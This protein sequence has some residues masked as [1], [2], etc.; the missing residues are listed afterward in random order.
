MENI[1]EII[2]LVFACITTSIAVFKW[3]RCAVHK[4]KAK[5]LGQEVDEETIEHDKVIEL[6]KNL[7]PKAMEYAETN[8]ANGETKKLLAMS[9]LM[10]DC[11]TINIDFSKYQSMIDDTIETFVDFSKKVNTKGE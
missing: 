6:I 11:N 3:V 5:C 2:L 7:I 10:L 1:R 4:A 8:G 9:K